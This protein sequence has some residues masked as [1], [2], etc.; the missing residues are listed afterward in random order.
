MTTKTP[1]PNT[2]GEPIPTVPSAPIPTLPKPKPPARCEDGEPIPTVPSAPI[3]TLPKPKPPT[4]SEEVHSDC[5]ADD[6]DVNGSLDFTIQL[7]W[8]GE[9]R[10]VTPT[11]PGSPKHV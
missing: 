8:V 5:M 1:T 11:P 2:L 4:R 10:C 3:P 7:H 6:E 9:E